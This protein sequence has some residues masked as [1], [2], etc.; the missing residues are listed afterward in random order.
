MITEGHPMLPRQLRIQA[1]TK[2]QGFHLMLAFLM[3]PLATQF[4]GCGEMVD[5]D[6]IRV[7]VY[8]DIYI[9]RGDLSTLLRE[10]DDAERPRISTKID[11]R[12]VLLKYIDEKISLPLGEKMAAEG[13]VQVDWNTALERYFANSGDDEEMYRQMW[14]MADEP[15]ERELALL[16]DYNIRPAMIKSFKELIRDGADAEVKRMHAEQAVALMSQEAFRTG[17]IQV[18][19][20]NLKL[21]YRLNKEEFQ[22]LEKMAFL[23]I[24]LPASP[25][26]MQ[27]MAQMREEIKKGVPFENIAATIQKRDPSL[28]ME[29]EIENNPEVDRFKGF[30]ESASGAQAGDIVGPVYMP[31]YQTYVVGAN[32]QPQRKDQ[33]KSWILFKVIESSPARNATY[34]ES[35]VELIPR[36]LVGE[37]KR[38][39]REAHKVE[40]FTDKLPDPGTIEGPAGVPRAQ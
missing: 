35:K 12:R 14:G 26:T 27:I 11:L 33:P 5:K 36:L 2:A 38:R 30:W 1:Y 22:Q 37:M 34:E 9:T 23:G 15:N 8:D 20:E 18:D 25:E 6:N 13:K 29:S 16:R 32:G 10:M 28:L 39:L 17:E 7:A 24:R 31:P 19:E 40:V 4:P 3:L 21:E